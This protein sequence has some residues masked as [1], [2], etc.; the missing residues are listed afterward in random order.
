MPRYESGGNLR[1]RGIPG[2]Q[3]RAYVAPPPPAPSP[4]E[5]L[6]AEVMANMPAPPP[7]PAPAQ[8]DP[9]YANDQAMVQEIFRLLNPSTFPDR[10]TVPS[11]NLPVI[12]PGFTREEWM[13]LSPAEQQAYLDAMRRA[14]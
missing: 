14:V 12:P 3:N 8:Q 11:P 1:V 2:Q 13:S 7:T 5:I 6:A 9:Y 10:P 4:A